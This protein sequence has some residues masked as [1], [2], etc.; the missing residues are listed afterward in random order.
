[1]VSGIS[2]L[3]MLLLIYARYNLGFLALFNLQ[4]AD[5]LMPAIGVGVYEGLLVTQGVLAFFLTLFIAPPMLARDLANNGLPL[6]LCRPLSRF[7]YVMGKMATLLWLLSCTTWIPG[8][9][10]W[11]LQA[12]MAGGGWGT[13]HLRILLGFVVGSWLWM[14]VLALLAFAISA[15][16]KWRLAAMAT[17]IGVFFIPPIFGNVIDARFVT[18]WGKLLNLLELM[19]VACGGLFGSYTAG[20][21]VVAVYDNGRA[22]DV[23]VRDL[24]Q[25]CAW[26]ALS[27]LCA[28][29]VFLLSRKVRAYEAVRG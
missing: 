27:L 29:C 20:E 15:W 25:W 8:L 26:A 14:A 22:I 23:V 5:Q 13:T 3:G 9:L 16:V 24:P 2:P 12:A 1:V 10:L 4:S 7:E 6:Y 28:T 21:S 17:L 18:H 11:G 19:H